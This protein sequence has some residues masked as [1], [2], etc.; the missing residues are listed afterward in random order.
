MVI[1]SSKPIIW[2]ILFDDTILS[3]YA[4]FY[5]RN[6]CDDHKVRYYISVKGDILIY[7]DQTNNMKK[8]RNSNVFSDCDNIWDIRGF[9]GRLNKLFEGLL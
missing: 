7:C 3:T 4:R 1:V 5:C 2:S 6:V 9:H 8:L